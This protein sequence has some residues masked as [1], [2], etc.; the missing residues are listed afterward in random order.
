MVVYLKV[1]R[2]LCARDM[3]VGGGVDSVG[4]TRGGCNDGDLWFRGVQDHVADID[5]G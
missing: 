2:R 4:Q 5:S 3:V 1:E